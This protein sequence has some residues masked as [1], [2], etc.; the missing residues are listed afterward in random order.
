MGSLSCYSNKGNNRLVKQNEW[1]NPYGWYENRRLNSLLHKQNITL[2]LTSKK[3]YKER[4][5]ARKRTGQNCPP[6]T[7][8]AH[9]VSCD[10]SPA[11]TVISDYDWSDSLSSFFCFRQSVLHEVGGAR[12]LSVSGS[13]YRI[14]NV[15]TEASSIVTKKMIICLVCLSIG[16][17]FQIQI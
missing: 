10:K 7:H 11:A 4:R 8:S 3:K 1:R 12:T 5:S 16:S 15:T 9:Y 14:L 13:R 17:S 6:I 2:S